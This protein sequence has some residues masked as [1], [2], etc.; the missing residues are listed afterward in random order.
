MGVGAWLRAVETVGSLAEFVGRVRGRASTSGDVPAGAGALETRLAGVVVAALKEAFDRD[1]VRME[2]EREQAEADQRRAEAALQAELRRQAIE[3]TLSQLRMVALMAL[4][5]WMLSALLGAWLE[6]MRSGLARVLL[7]TGWAF[8][9]A[10]LGCAFAGWPRS[11]G[12]AA[13]RMP[14]ENAPA[15]AAPWLLVCALVLIAA[16]LLVAL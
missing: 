8:A 12:S 1:R 11:T 6:G 9:F 14:D 15:A 4:S 16:S 3:R 10:S 13:A 2:I 5:A 7:G